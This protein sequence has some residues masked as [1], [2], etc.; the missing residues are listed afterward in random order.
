MIARAWLRHSMVLLLGGALLGAASAR[1]DGELFSFQ[2]A[3]VLE[4]GAQYA[5]RIEESAYEP[6]PSD[7]SNDGSWWGIDAG[8][9]A[10]L[11][12]RFSVEIDGRS[13]APPRKLCRDLAELHGAEVIEE[14]GHLIV[15]IHGGE[16][17]GSFDAQFD[18][19]EHEIE[20]VVRMGERP[21]E[22]WERTIVH[23]SAGDAASVVPG[24]ALPE[25]LLRFALAAGCTPPAD[26]Y[27]EH[28]DAPKPPFAYAAGEDTLERAAVLWCRRGELQ[29]GYSLL[30]RPGA[31][32]VGQGDCP[33]EI[34]AR[35]SIGGLSLVP[36]ADVEVSWL[37]PLS[38]PSAPALA[39]PP[40]ASLAIR[41]E[42]DGVGS[43]FVCHAGQ[44]FRYG[45]R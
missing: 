18:F 39:D 23:S 21:D 25:E 36:I 5:V 35:P 3:G 9:P 38:D 6:G 41:S 33:A 15:R 30:F 20:R 29:E 4:S 43:Y 14:Q 2:K 37:R 19:R 28:P 42:Y 1:A 10:T 12:S 7:L 13:A 17:H 31:G 24:A 44:W 45:F 34:S 27:A 26:F 22:V 32:D 8:F 16:A 11:C 40:T